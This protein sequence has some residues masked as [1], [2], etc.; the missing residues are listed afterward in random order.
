M[1]IFRSQPMMPMPTLLPTPKFL[2]YELFKTIVLK[3]PQLHEEI[4]TVQG[5]IANDQPNEFLGFA[6][7]DTISRR[8]V[9]IKAI[10]RL[11]STIIQFL[12]I[13]NA[14]AVKCWISIA[15]LRI[16]EVLCLNNRWS[17]YTPRLHY[18]NADRL[19]NVFETTACIFFF[20]WMFWSE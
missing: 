8:H 15:L 4:S 3:H 7:N 5:F 6:L 18:N 12:M 10:S 11:H 17:S 20:R 14:V 19:K 1:S 13:I 16:F 9:P 2:R